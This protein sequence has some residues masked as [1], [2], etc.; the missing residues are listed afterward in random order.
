MLV[1]RLGELERVVFPYQSMKRRQFKLL[2]GD[3][4]SLWLENVMLSKNYAEYGAGF[5]T[6]FAGKYAKCRVRTAESDPNWAA[7]V[8][9]KTPRRVLVHQI[10]FGP[11]GP[12]GRPLS[13]EFSENFVHYFSAPFRGGFSPDFV[14]VDGRFRV[15]C[16]LTSVLLSEPGTRI[17]IDDYVERAG[18][19]CV[20]EVLSPAK[21]NNRQALFVRP[22]QVDKKQIEQ[23]ILQKKNSA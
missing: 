13:D 2:R 12:W 8:S 23:L 21:V 20:E 3:D 5:S 18:Y 15:A 7:M 14:Y 6:I 4:H 22:V 11:V 1:K 10:D 19:H 16:F 17:V 9:K